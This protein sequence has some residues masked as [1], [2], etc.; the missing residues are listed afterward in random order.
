MHV[1]CFKLV[2]CY[3]LNDRYLSLMCSNVEKR[4]V[5]LFFVHVAFEGYLF[6]LFYSVLDDNICDV[7]CAIA[8]CRSHLVRNSIVIYTPFK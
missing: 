4:L 6:K 1:E 5:S 7:H 8:E 2:F 3:H